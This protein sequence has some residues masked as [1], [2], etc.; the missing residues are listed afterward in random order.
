MTWRLSSVGKWLLGAAGKTKVCDCCDEG[1]YLLACPCFIATTE[2]PTIEECGITEEP[3]IGLDVRSELD[4]AA[5]QLWQRWHEIWAAWLAL[6]P[7]VVKIGDYCYRITPFFVADPGVSAETRAAFLADVGAPE[8]FYPTDILTGTATVGG[9]GTTLDRVDDCTEDS[10]CDAFPAGGAWMECFACDPEDSLIVRNFVC[11]ANQGFV[12]PDTCACIDHAIRY[13][14]A[15]INTIELGEVIARHL[16][17]EYATWWQWDAA[18]QEFYCAPAPCCYC[19][20]GLG[21]E[22]G[23]GEGYDL[24]VGGREWHNIDTTTLWAQEDVCCGKA[25][26]LRFAVTLT[27]YYERTYTD[28][29]GVHFESTEVENVVVT[30]RTGGGSTVEYDIHRI[31]MLNGVVTFDD[32]TSSG[33]QEWGPFCCLFGNSGHM[34][35]WPGTFS[36]HSVVGDGPDTPGSDNCAVQRWQEYDGNWTNATQLRAAWEASPWGTLDTLSDVLP[37]TR[38]SVGEYASDRCS[39]ASFTLNETYT[40]APDTETR[41]VDISLEVTVLY[42]NSQPCVASGGCST[43]GWGTGAA[44]EYL[45]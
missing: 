25:E 35:P 44:W 28:G 19:L 39:N 18:L 11:A 27:Y 38:V 31:G 34:V 5:G 10:G 30:D 22:G 36:D 45:P 2:P 23:G 13:S 32:T 4:D 21:F 1:V 15:E 24:C 17:L 9:K 43:E 42:D 12:L 14:D 16:T 26:T 40:Y 20:S 29:S 7:F 3:C 8:E 37:G 41:S 33:P 6:E